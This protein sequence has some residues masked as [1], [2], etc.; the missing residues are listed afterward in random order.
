V[1]TGYI[2]ERESPVGDGFSIIVADTETTD[3]TYT[4]TGLDA[5]TEYNYRVSA[6]NS[7]GTSV[8]SSTA[9]ATTN[10]RPSFE[11]P[12]TPTPTLEASTVVVEQED[13]RAIFSWES[14]LE[15]SSALS[16]GRS[17]TSLAQTTGTLSPRMVHEITLENLSP[18]TE[19]FYKVSLFTPTAIL[20]TPV[21]SFTTPEEEEEFEQLS[22]EEVTQGFSYV[23]IIMDL[24][25][26]GIT[27][28][29]LTSSQALSGLTQ[30]LSILEEFSLSL[31]S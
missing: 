8:A 21:Q 18:S 24:I 27:T 9:S 28:H 3:T 17:P 5:Q 26:G 15:A 31:E 29:S 30:L 10:A 2:I 20:V 11:Q 16:W 4:D 6:L 7:G 22:Q 23:R 25:Q 13:T 1:I 19:Y 12:S 14:N